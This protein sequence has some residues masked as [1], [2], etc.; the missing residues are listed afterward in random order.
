MQGLSDV[1]ALVTPGIHHD[2]GVEVGWK[3]RGS[4][5]GQFHRTR[6]HRAEVHVGEHR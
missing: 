6:A 3:R 5:T 1:Q 4:H 2:A